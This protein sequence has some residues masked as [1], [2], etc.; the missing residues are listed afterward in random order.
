M[1]PYLAKQY[2]GE[3]TEVVILFDKARHN[4]FVRNVFSGKFLLVKGDKF[5]ILLN[6]PKER[7]LVYLAERLAIRFCRYIVELFRGHILTEESF[8]L[9][10]TEN[11]LCRYPLTKLFYETLENN[12]GFNIPMKFQNDVDYTKIRNLEKDY[13]IVAFYFRKKGDIENLGDY[14][15]SGSSMKDYQQIFD[16]FESQECVVLV[17]GD[18]DRNESAQFTQR[19]T[20]VFACTD[21]GIS[22]D[23]WNLIVPLLASYVIGNAGGGIVPAVLTKTRIL[24]IDGYGYWYGVPNALH[25]FKLLKDNL[26]RRFNPVNFMEKDPWGPRRQLELRPVSLPPALISEVLLEFWS[27]R[28]QD[29]TTY[30]SVSNLVLHQDNWLGWTQSGKISNKYLDYVKDLPFYF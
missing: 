20:N 22:S 21:L 27:L 14:H 23:K 16:F 9:D 5:R 3:L 18:L 4:P 13:E 28:N 30:S 24:I 29:L 10:F 11:R 1:Q 8:S 2:F 17:Y 26:G 7:F 6:L 12:Q 15:R 25:T 19:Y